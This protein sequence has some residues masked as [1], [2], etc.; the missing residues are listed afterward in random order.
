MT[1]PKTVLSNYFRKLVFNVSYPTHSQVST[2]S[3]G[4]V[5]NWTLSRFFSPLFNLDWLFK[6]YNHLLICLSCYLWFC[7][8]DGSLV[9]QQSSKNPY[10]SVLV[11]VWRR[12]APSLSVG[13]FV[14]LYIS[15]S[16]SFYPSHY[17]QH[18][19]YLRDWASK[20]KISPVTI[21]GESDRG[22]GGR[23]PRGQS[24]RERGRDARWQVDREEG[25]WFVW[26]CFRWSKLC[27]RHLNL[28][29]KV[30]FEGVQS[31]HDSLKYV[32]LRV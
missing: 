19:G 8:W 7:C 31:K 25:P 15:L 5:R 26:Q 29:D 16:L 1:I 21:N 24:K 4:C 28:A 17:M 22:Q 30:L 18:W 10:Q 6:S 27:L 20:E 32:T 9:N 23:G 2:F 3:S 13:I 12:L 14:C 11:Y